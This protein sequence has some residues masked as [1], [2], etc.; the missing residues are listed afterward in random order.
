MTE[1]VN[2]DNQWHLS[3]S[4]PISLIAAMLLQTFAAGSWAADVNARLAQTKIGSDAG[5]ENQSRIAR[6]EA[7]AEAQARQLDRIEDKLDALLEKEQR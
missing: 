4:V 1:Q 6:I 7:V 2:S 5:I 3:K